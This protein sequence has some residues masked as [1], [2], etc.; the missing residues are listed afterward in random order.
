MRIDFRFTGRAPL[1]TPCGV[2][3]GGGF[4]AG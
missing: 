4:R 3:A 2:L 1:D